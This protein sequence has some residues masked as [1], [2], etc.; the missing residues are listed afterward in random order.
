[1]RENS[2]TSLRSDPVEIIDHH[3]NGGHPQRIADPA[4]A[5]VHETVARTIYQLRKRARLTQEQ[6]AQMV[7]T[8]TSVICRLEN[9]EYEGHSLAMLRRIASALNKRLELR[10]V[11]THRRTKVA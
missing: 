2:K 6:L 11:G 3:Y 9:V 10:F 5:E 8:T 1:M 4:E 7:G